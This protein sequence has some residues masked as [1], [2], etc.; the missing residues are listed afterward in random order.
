LQN[1]A[2]PR[3]AA[4]VAACALFSAHAASQDLALPPR[5]SF[6]RET[7]EA[8]TR[9]QELW[10]RYSYKE[11]RTELHMNPFGRMGTGGTR[12]TEVRPSADPR[13]TYRRVVERGG[14]P[15]SRFELDRQ[16]AEYRERVADVK[17][18][19]ASA[20]DD[21]RNHR[22][23]DDRLAQRRAQMVVDDVVKT[24]QFD[25]VRRELRDGK[26]AIVISFAGR[27]DGRPTTR[28]GRLAKAFAGNLF[29]DEATREVTYLEGVAR[30]DVSFG[31]FIAKV[32]QGTKA[33]VVREEVEPGVWM[34]TR[35]T[36]T[37]DIRALFRKAKIDHVVEW[38]EY[39]RNQ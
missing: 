4:L 11:R 13:L 36:L 20:D 26:P 16:D 28:E 22:D 35:L 6:L 2:M 34:P 14:V 31:G 24:M 37:G 3:R 1:E 32:Y 18:Q 38:F 29:V 7:R 19:G 9:S 21:D 39:R 30:Y 25:L 5:D 33:V 17:R 15:V 27:P 23:E 8:L 12:V 10:H